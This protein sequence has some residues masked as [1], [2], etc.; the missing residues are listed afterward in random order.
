M[1]PTFVYF[2]FSLVRLLAL[3]VSIVFCSLN[4]QGAT[5]EVPSSNNQYEGSIQNAIDQAESGDIILV[6]PGT[7][8]ENIELWEKKPYSPI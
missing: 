7:Y 2:N 4:T 3:G 8:V 5:L 1:K 6:H